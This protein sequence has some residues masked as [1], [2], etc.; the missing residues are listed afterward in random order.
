MIIANVSGVYA[1]IMND[2]GE[3]FTV[4]DKNGEEA[5]DIIITS[6]SNDEEAV[7]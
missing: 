6:I 7:V 1:R 5:Q 4:I 3:D 2:F